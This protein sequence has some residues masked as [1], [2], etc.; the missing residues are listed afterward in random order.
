MRRLCVFAAALAL[1]WAVQASW[2]WPFGSSDGDSSAP[3]RRLSEL[4][5][6]ASRL[7]DEASDFASEG[8]SQEAV[9]K[10]REALAELDRIEAENP[11]RTAS[12]EF[13][14]VRN[15]R[16]YVNAAIDSLLLEQVK[17]NAKAVAVSDTSEL[18]RRFAAEKA[19][20]S[21][22][23]AKAPAPAK[24][25]PAPKPAKKAAGGDARAKEPVRQ[26]SGKPLPLREQAIADIAAGDYAAAERKIG[27]MLKEKPN[28][29]MALN[30]KASLEAAQGKRKEAEST[31]DQAIMSNPRSYYAY[32]NMASL[33]LKGGPDGKKVARRYYE[34]GRV[35]GGP[36]DPQLEESLK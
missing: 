31:L 28:G 16:A 27:E 10:Y 26:A 25:A 21:G 15:K 3:V 8:K 19:K 13:S 14:T 24:A 2:Y 1:S 7:I 22:V 12:P 33:L 4:M 20:A 34:T 6:P 29:A 35:V 23:D 36:P 5:E 30:L 9:E 32:Y 18:E 17:N 11:E